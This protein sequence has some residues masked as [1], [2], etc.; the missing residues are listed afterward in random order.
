M[1]LALLLFLLQ[2]LGAPQNQ[3]PCQAETPQAPTF[4]IQ[5]VDPSWE[6]VASAN[7]TLISESNG[8]KVKNALTD[9]QRYAKF[10]LPVE[11]HDQRYAVKVELLG[12]KRSEVKD[13]PFPSPESTT[14]YVQIR[15]AVDPKGNVTVY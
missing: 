8:R 6:P 15:L 10:S 5:A 9:A 4:V 2:T 12:F 13:I 7:V 1:W 11:G 3:S 14:A